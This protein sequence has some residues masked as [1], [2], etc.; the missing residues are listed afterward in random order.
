[1]LN[2][3]FPVGDVTVRVRNTEISS[4]SEPNGDF[5]LDLPVSDI[6]RTVVLDIIGDAVVE[7]GIEITVP[8][9]AELIIVDTKVGART[10]PITFNLET[11]GELKNEGGATGTSVS[12]PANAL[13]FA[14]GT[15]ATGD[16]QV[17]ITEIDIDDLD[18]ASAWAP[19]LIGLEEGMTEPTV[20]E[21][22]GMADFRFSQDGRELNLRPG[23]EATLKMHI[24]SPYFVSD[25]GGSAEVVEI[26]EGYT[27]PLWHY[28]TEDLIWKEEGA[29][30]V[31]A[32]EESASGVSWSGQVSHFSTWN[33][34]KSTS[35]AWVTVNVNVVD[36]NGRS[37]DGLDAT[38]WTLHGTSM[39][40]STNQVQIRS[41]SSVRINLAGVRP[42]TYYSTN[43]SVS[44][45]VVNKVGAVSP[46]LPSLQTVTFSAGNTG[47][48]T[49]TFTVTVDLGPK[50]M[51]ANVNL[52][53]VN[54]QDQAIDNITIVRYRATANSIGTSWSN[55]A[56]LTPASTALS[57][58]GNTKAAVDFGQSVTTQ[59]SVDNI[60][61]TDAV[62]GDIVS[63]P[64]PQTRLFK[65]YEGDNTLTF[66]IVIKTTPTE[67]MANLNIKLVDFQG[68]PLNN[69]D[70]LSFRVTTQASGSSTA[71]TQQT[72][73]SASSQLSVQGNTQLLMNM[74]KTVTTDITIDNI[75]IEEPYR[76]FADPDPQSIVFKTFE[77][78]TVTFEVVAIPQ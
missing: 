69:V 66:K 40:P 78:N 2:D 76:V 61:I 8:A 67:L 23:V 24:L 50:D 52:V 16:A 28:D 58:Q 37:V 77:D 45:V 62:S 75:V 53:A 11:G 72:L 33:G 13:Q 41:Y 10:L 19:R 51:T 22:F 73:T 26:V 35:Y 65:T 42:V 56:N 55:S 5:T 7:K 15:I 3:A 20:L 31:I 4:V 47:N 29:A 38:S 21:S 34:D 9:E 1:M 25:E 30:I 44:N 14:D 60:V 70:L 39:T 71:Q 63:Y 36:Q 17:S 57:V 54:E 48:R 46:A 64:G 43:F 74:G 59:V 49:L 18:G 32:D 27:I 6:E 12:L 68:Q